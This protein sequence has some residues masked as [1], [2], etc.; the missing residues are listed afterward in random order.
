MRK[1]FVYGLLPGRSKL[2]KSREIEL[3]GNL[4]DRFG[5]ILFLVPV[6]VGARSAVRGGESEHA[7]S[8]IRVPRSES[9][10]FIDHEASVWT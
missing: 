10:P 3:S 4:D 6:L 7:S 5:S 8:Q 9:L 2:S 1:W